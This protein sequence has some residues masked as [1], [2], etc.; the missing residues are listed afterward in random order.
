MQHI[1]LKN[2]LREVIFLNLEPNQTSYYLIA[3]NNLYK[4]L[5]ILS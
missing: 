4:T 1:H 5:Q 2:I 3:N